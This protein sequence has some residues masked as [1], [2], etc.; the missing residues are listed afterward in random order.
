MSLLFTIVYAA[1]ANGTHHKLALDALRYLPRGDAEPWRRVFLKYAD[2]YM[3]GS[4]AP[5]DEF[6]DFKNHVLHVRD[7]YWGG[8]PEKA[9]NWY[10]HL[11]EALRESDFER[12]V[13]AAGVLSHYYT[14]PIHPF[15]TAQSDA[16]SS[17]HRAV[18]WSI[19][20]SYDGLR[21]EGET[22]HHDEAPALPVGDDWLRAHVIA[23]AERSNPHYETLIT[24]YDFKT[25]VR[26]PTAG[27][28]PIARDAVSALLIYAAKGFALVLDRAITEAAVEPPEVS[29]TA[30]TVL[31]TLK[32]PA[33]WITKKIADTEVRRQ[34]QAM[35]DELMATGRVEATLPEDDRVV[36]NLYQKEVLEPRAKAMA[37]ERAKRLAPATAVAKTSRAP[38]S[39][40]PAAVAGAHNSAAVAPA[41]NQ[42]VPPLQVMEAKAKNLPQSVPLSAGSSASNRDEL[43][44][45]NTVP[46]CYLAESDDLERAPS[47]GPK[48]A[49]R[50]A[51]GGIVSVKDFIDAEPDAVV[52]LLGEGRFDAETVERWKTEARL[53]LRVPGL[54]GTHAQLLAGAG[55]DTPEKLADADPVALSAAVLAFATTPAGARILRNGDTPDI[56]A[57]TRWVQGA[58]QALAA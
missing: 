17:V 24:H 15:H 11:V 23:G 40:K 55:Y 58:Q 3:T 16:E 37:A 7:S 26:E 5:D 27:L 46:R 21:A 45:L 43:S 47:I 6:K 51:L 20:R 2:V 30:E 14:D 52:S 57:V 49:E 31:A 28:N 25:G 56:E 34:V 39:A 41:H 36:R 19:N 8:A 1:H 32:M 50:L 13:Y 33:K 18:E 38:S 35:Y 12:A 53:V 22:K 9:A 42:P 4:K 44:R 10:G 54:R 29:L 48:L